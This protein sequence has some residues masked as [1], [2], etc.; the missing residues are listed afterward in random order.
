MGNCYSSKKPKSTSASP[1]ITPLRHSSNPIVLHSLQL[2][3]MELKRIDSA[4]QLVISTSKLYKRRTNREE[5]AETR[6]A[7]E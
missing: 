1:S 3:L 2:K 5:T 4:P 7:A 6:L